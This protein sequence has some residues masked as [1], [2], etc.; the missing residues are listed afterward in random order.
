[1]APEKFKSARVTIAILTV[2]ILTMALSASLQA[3][4]PVFAPEGRALAGFDVVAYFTRGKAVKGDP[5]IHYRW[6]DVEWRFSSEDH[7]QLFMQ[8]PEKYLPRYGG[9]CALGAAHGGL[10][11][12]SPRAWSIH[13]GKLIMNMNQDVVETW[14]YNPDINIERADRNW[15]TLRERFI[16]SQDAQ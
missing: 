12:S 5:A 10:V 6:S 7:R 16:A 13:D 9:F 2:L 11:P 15:P 8:T 1:M 4:E 14:R 3:G